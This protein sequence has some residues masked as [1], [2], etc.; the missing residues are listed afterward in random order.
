MRRSPLHLLNSSLCAVP[1]HSL[2]MGLLLCL[3]YKKDLEKVGFPCV[4]CREIQ[5]ALWGIGRGWDPQKGLI[6]RSK[7]S[8]PRPR[9]W[10][11]FIAPGIISEDSTEMAWLMRIWYSTQHRVLLPQPWSTH[12][13]SPNRGFG[14]YS[15]LSL[16]KGKIFLCLLKMTGL[17]HKFEKSLKIWRIQ[18]GVKIS[19]KG[20]KIRIWSPLIRLNK[21]VIK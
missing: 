9:P 4:S 10:A 5:P 17:H 7:G 1:S 2:V 6:M 8:H 19:N 21:Y 18:L 16:F 11:A 13:A 14:V 12:L 20:N 15:M 3:N